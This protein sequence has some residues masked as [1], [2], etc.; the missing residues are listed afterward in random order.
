MDWVEVL[1]PGVCSCSSR[2]CYRHQTQAP[3]PTQQTAGFTQHALPQKHIIPDISPDIDHARQTAIG[4]PPH[5]RPLPQRC[6]SNTWQGDAGNAKP[7]V[8]MTEQAVPH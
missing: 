2:H 5:S 1:A 4:A 8:T 3:L 6:R 7:V